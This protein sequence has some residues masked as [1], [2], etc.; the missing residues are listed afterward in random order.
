MPLTIRILTEYTVENSTP[1]KNIKISFIQGD[2][3]TPSSLGTL[4]WKGPRRMSS[5][6]MFMEMVLPLV[7]WTFSQLRLSKMTSFSNGTGVKMHVL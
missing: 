6:L 2:G 5:G 3:I 1:S 7:G 4:E